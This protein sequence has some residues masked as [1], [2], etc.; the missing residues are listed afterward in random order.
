M[1][2]V[3]ALTFPGDEM[4][5]DRL[6]DAADGTELQDRRGRRMIWSDEKTGD[7]ASRIRAHWQ[8][9]ADAAANIEKGQGA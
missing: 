2:N 7:W 9:V 4:G 5:P 8:G 1:E 3:I 6:R